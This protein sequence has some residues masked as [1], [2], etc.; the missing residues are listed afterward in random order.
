MAQQQLLYELALSL[1]P[2]REVEPF[3]LRPQH[4]REVT[5]PRQLAGLYERLLAEPQGLRDDLLEAPEAGR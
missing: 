1:R 4:E 3:H 2:D 5:A